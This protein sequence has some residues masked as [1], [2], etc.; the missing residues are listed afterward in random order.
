MLEVDDLL[1][2]RIHDSALGRNQLLPLVRA[3]VE[4]AAVHLQRS[5]ARSAHR[6]LLLLVRAAVEEAAVSP[7]APH[8]SLSTAHGSVQAFNAK[9]S[10]PGRKPAPTCCTWAIGNWCKACGGL[11]WEVDGRV[12][13]SPRSSHTPVRRWR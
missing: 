10:D 5:T 4:E 3:A 2:A 8:I 13:A 1:H 11:H 6:Q 9:G 12:S 7:A